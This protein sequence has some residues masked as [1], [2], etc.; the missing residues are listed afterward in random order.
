MAATMNS[1]SSSS[2][3]E[4]QSLPS[5]KSWFLGN[6]RNNKKRILVLDG[7]VSTHLEDLL[8]AQ[9]KSTKFQH[10]ELWSSS[11]LLT[12]DGKE[13]ICRG[14]GDWIDAGC[15]VITTVTYQCHY[16]QE[17]WPPNNIVN[18]DDCMDQMWKDGLQLAR[19]AVAS[20]YGD[21]GEMIQQQSSGGTTTTTTSVVETTNNNNRRPPPRRHIYVMASSGCYGAALANGAEY[22]GDYNDASLQNLVDF[23]LRKLEAIVPLQPDVIAIETVP[24]L[25]ECRALSKLFSDDDH[26]H[27]DSGATLLPALGQSACFISLSCRNDKEINDGTPLPVALDALRNIPTDKVQGLG[28]NCCDGIFL[29]GLVRTLVKDMATKGPVRR[30]IVLYPNSGET[31]DSPTQTWKEGK[32]CCRR[33]GGELANL[34]LRA[35][36]TAETVWR[37]HRPNGDP[38]PSILL[39]GCCRTRPTAMSSLRELVDAHLLAEK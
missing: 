3:A 33:Q 25:L 21:N 4:P 9:G 10:K 16:Q 37:T 15:D 8:E 39:G 32:S 13:L 11:L 18:G 36:T 35:V 24:S 19:K 17:M 2:T 23:H 27:N 1:K 26:D 29:E 22:T 5:L 6:N 14:H 28:L 12:E 34:L 20:Y 31:W 30:G 7:G 38:I